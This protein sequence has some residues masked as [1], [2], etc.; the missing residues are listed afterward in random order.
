MK[1]IRLPVQKMTREAFAPYGVLIDSRGSVEVDFGLGV[2]AR[3]RLDPLRLDVAPARQGV[4]REPG[5]RS[6]P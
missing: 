3:A 5:R 2:A 1:V 6:A 4:L